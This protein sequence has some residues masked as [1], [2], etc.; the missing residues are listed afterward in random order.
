MLKFKCGGAINLKTL[1][2]SCHLTEYTARETR[3]KHYQF[4]C[5]LCNDYLIFDEKDNWDRHCNFKVRN[6]NRPNIVI[7]NF[8]AET[9]VI[10][11][12]ESMF[13]FRLTGFDFQLCFKQI[14]SW[15]V[16]CIIELQLFK[17]A[18]NSLAQNSVR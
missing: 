17:Y 2:A 12:C 4:V 16:F 10:F 8:F 5:Q 3:F 13:W 6:Q 11:H 15:K 18:A 7:F 9:S 14:N 1:K